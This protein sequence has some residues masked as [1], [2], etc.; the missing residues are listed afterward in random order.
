[1]P[2]DAPAVLIDT[3]VHIHDCFPLAGFLD[4]AH[5]NFERATRALGNHEGFIGILML[6][7]TAGVDCF[8]RLSVAAEGGAEAP[9][10]GEWRLRRTG[11]SG[12][13]VAELDGR[14]LYLV[15]GR[16]IVTAERLEVLALGFEG[17][18]PDGEPI[19]Q[20]LERVRAAGALAVVPWGF[21]KWW[22][23]R[24]RVV[25]GLLRDHEALGFYLG[26]NSG[27]ATILGR[28]AHFEEADRLGIPILPGTDPLPFPAEYGRA[29]GFGLVARTP[30]DPARPAAEAK[31]VL[32]GRRSGTT[33]YGRLETPLRF[34]RNQIAMQLYKHGVS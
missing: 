21:G 17:F 11:E 13:V 32:T 16:Q 7:E 22:G 33:P 14:C 15:A 28:P 3:H 1:M 20:V 18:I 25:S 4:A 31:R 12:S 9:G 34:V 8:R 29:G 19:R 23:A 24:G 6:T 26:D 27:R 30:I 2:I 5:G 10:L